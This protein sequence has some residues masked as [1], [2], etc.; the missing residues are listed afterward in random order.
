M[1][2]TYSTTAYSTYLLLFGLQLMI[3]SVV[4]SNNIPNCDVETYSGGYY[5]CSDCAI[6][7]FVKSFSNNNDQCLDCPANCS[8]CTSATVCETCLENYVLLLDKTCK[9]CNDYH[10]STCDLTG[11]CTQ[12][13]SNYFMEPSNSTC[14]ACLPG[15]KTCRNSSSCEACNIDYKLKQQDGKDVCDSQFGSFVVAATSVALWFILVIYV[16][17]PI[18]GLFCLCGGIWAVA[19]C[20]FG[21]CKKSSNVY[22]PGIIHGGP[23]QIGQPQNLIVNSQMTQLQ[24]GQFQPN[25]FQEVNIQPLQNHQQPIQ[26][27]P[28]SY[29]PPQTS[30]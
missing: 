8:I 30:F 25:Q 7:Y 18:I 1:Q 19:V 16:I 9:R 5:K 13:S 24:P 12:C 29:K 23:N 17:V 10:C 3:E 4:A 21:C 14:T 26:Y 2:I 15:C 22:G 6:N 28:V 20:C 27:Q 11:K